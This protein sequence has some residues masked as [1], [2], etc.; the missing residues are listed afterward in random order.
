M[1]KQRDV[2]KKTN[3]RV[4]KVTKSLTRN[5]NEK[6]TKEEKKTSTPPDIISIIENR[7]DLKIKR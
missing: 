4:Q 5:K 6:R 2:I 7:E 1:N 3:E